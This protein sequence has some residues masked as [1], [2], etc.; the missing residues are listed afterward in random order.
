MSELRD[1]RVTATE[2]TGS[3]KEQ[4]VTIDLLELLY[5]LIASWKLIVIWAFVGALIAGIYTFAF[6]TPLYTATS[7]IYVLSNSDSVINMSDL[8]IGSALTS[9]YIKVFDMWEVHEGVISNLGLPYSYSKIKGMLSVT[10]TSNTRMLDITVTSSSPQEAA[11]ISNEYARVVSQFIEET[12]STDKPNIMS[13]ALVPANP[14]SPRKARNIVMGF[15][16]GLMI[17]VAIVVV[18]MIIDDKLRT[19]EDIRK[20]TGLVTLATVPIETSNKRKS[21]SAK[22]AKTS[23]KSSGGK[24]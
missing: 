18:R 10:N 16:L 17:G 13:T 19:S 15:L 5:R 9:D 6:V 11:D 1:T 3:S 23:T 12:M 22:N 7:T 14:V 21:V 4:E 2:S 8:Q 20:A 24:V